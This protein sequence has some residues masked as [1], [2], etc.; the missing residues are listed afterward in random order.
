[1][2][3]YSSLLFL[4]FQLPIVMFKSFA[5]SGRS[6]VFS[7][8]PVGTYSMGFV[9]TCRRM[10]LGKMKMRIATMEVQADVIFG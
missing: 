1:M 2:K 4:P 9:K 7:I 10:S 5:D 8:R 3:S 6:C